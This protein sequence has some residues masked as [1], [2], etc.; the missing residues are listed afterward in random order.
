MSQY[1]RQLLADIRRH[2][3][4]VDRR[5]AIR[6]LQ[7]PA[8]L[9]P[10]FADDLR[11]LDFRSYIDRI[12]TLD[13]FPMAEREHIALLQARAS[14]SQFDGV[15]MIASE[16]L[17]GWIQGKYAS[18]DQLVLVDMSAVLSSIDTAIGSGDGPP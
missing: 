10:S 11:V 4:A 17:R 1:I 15:T 16:A 13:G 14:F 12:N 2:A 8:D 5:S 7:L 9:Q 18:P 6:D 3:S